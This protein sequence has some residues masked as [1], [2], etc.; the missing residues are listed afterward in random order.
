M[1]AYV[2]VNTNNYVVIKQANPF[3]GVS[4]LYSVYNSSLIFLFFI[5]Q[6]SE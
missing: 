5:L 2:K 6:K 4:N 1:F 3:A